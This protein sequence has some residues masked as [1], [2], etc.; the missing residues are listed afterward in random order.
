VLLVMTIF[1]LASLARMILHVRSGGAYASYVL[2][3]SIVLF[4]Y[5]W[6]SPF[7]GILREAR[8]VAIA[9]GIA[10][11]LMALSAVINSCVLAYRYQTRNTVAITTDRGRMITKP[12]MAQAVNEA[13]R[14]IDRETAPGDAVAVLPEGTTITFLSGRR[15]PLREEII[16]P[17]YLDAEGEAR[18]I[19]QLRDARTPLI[20]VPNRPTREFGP[21]VFGRDYSQGLMQFIEANYSACAIF[22]PVKDRNL[23]IGDPPF[24]IRAYCLASTS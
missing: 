22:G 24:F 23:K 16:T 9:R 19:R 2:P 20:L 14:Y 10:V 18:A 8:A 13:L 5:M 12:D 1:A 11:T 7:A 4:A 21:N 15:N 6:V 17:G 3:V